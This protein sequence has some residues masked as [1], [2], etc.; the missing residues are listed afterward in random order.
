MA[1][2]IAI[3]AKTKVAIKITTVAALPLNKLFILFI[4]IFYGPT[5]PSDS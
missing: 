1:V 2:K 3:P 5:H 4:F